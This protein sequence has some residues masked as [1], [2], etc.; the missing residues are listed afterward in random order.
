MSFCAKH[1]SDS[2][3]LLYNSHGNQCEFSE[4]F[5]DKEN[6][7]PGRKGTQQDYSKKYNLYFAFLPSK[8]CSG[9]KLM[10]F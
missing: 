3:K 1:H 4:C 6:S 5:K 9:A 8:Y 10:Y 2:A 7:A